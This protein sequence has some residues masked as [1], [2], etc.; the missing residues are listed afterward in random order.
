MRAFII[1]GPC[2]G[3]VLDVAPPVPATREAVID[4]DRVG[5][6]GTDVSAFRGELHFLH[7]GHASYPLRIGHEWTGVV[8]EVGNGVDHSWL[9]KRVVGD[10]MLGC[11]HCQLCRSGR[12]HVCDDRYEVGVRNGWHGALAEKLLMPV[13]ALQ[14]CPAGIDAT[15]GAMVE[16]GANA[17][18]AVR[19][20]Q[21]QRGRATLIIGPGAIG[22]LAALFARELGSDVH[23][24]GRSTANPKV[25]AAKERGFTV[26]GMDEPPN[27]RFWSVIEASGGSSAPALAVDLVEPGG[28]IAFVGLSARPSTVDSRDLVLKD[29]TAIGLLGGSSAIEET[30]HYYATGAVDPHPLVERVIGLDEVGEALGASQLGSAGR[31]KVHVDPRQ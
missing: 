9:G 31:P 28:T 25:T 21:V 1:T 29:I 7:D 26:W 23:V 12:A 11:G 14:E 4:V 18:R 24:L 20:T 15:V 6:C 13:S 5:L 10:T 8:S 19:V 2:R 17:L 27:Q 16:P 3:Q 30:I 22:I